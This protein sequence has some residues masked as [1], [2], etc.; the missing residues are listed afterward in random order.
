MKDHFKKLFDYNIWANTKLINCIKNQQITDT[1]VLKLLSHIVLAE[2]IWMKRLKSGNYQ[3]KN[4]W[5]VLDIAECEKISNVNYQAYI[6]LI[7]GKK[8]E[9]EF[10]NTIIYKN[11]KGIEYTNSINNILTHVSF[12]SAYHRGQIAREVRKLNKE[13]VLTDYIAYVRENLKH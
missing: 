4:F 3:N 5:Q 8:D 10:T 2:Q 7:N 12:H 13:P 11:S 9:S 6:E 1:D